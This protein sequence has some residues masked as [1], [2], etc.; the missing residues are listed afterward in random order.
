MLHEL[1]IRNFAIIDDLHLTFGPGL[2]ILTGE[3]G[4]GKSIIIDALGLLQGDRGAAEWVRAGTELAQIEAIF[5]LPSGSEV[6]TEVSRILAEQELDDPDSPDWITLNREVRRNGRNVCRVN[7]RN[8]S[9]QILSD[10]AALLID[11]HGQGEHLNLLRPRTHIRLLD[12]FASLMPLRNQLAQQVA[13]LRKIRAELQRL[14]QD[15]RT[16][17]QRVDLLSFQAEEIAQARLRPG[18]EETLAS[19]RLRLGNAEALLQLAQAAATILNVGESEMPGAI[20]LVSEA[21]GRIERLARIDRSMQSSADDAQG[22]LE[23]LSDLAR[24]LQDYADQLEFNPERLQEVEERLELIA[25]LKRK[26]GDTLEQIIA[27]GERAQTELDSLSN[28]EVKTAELEEQEDK[29][30]HIIG[31]L[32]W[33]LSAERRQAGETLARRVE[34]ELADLRMER[35]RFGVA[36]EQSERADGAYLPDGRRVAFDNTGIDQVEFLISANPGE[37]LKPMAKVASG[38]ETARLMLALKSVLTHADATPTLI[39]DEIDQGIGGRVGAVVGQKLWFLTGQQHGVNGSGPSR[40][41]TAKKSAKERITEKATAEVTEK[42]HDTDE[43]FVPHQVLCITHL[44]QLA[45][46]GDKHFTVNKRVFQVEGEERTST[47]VRDLDAAERIE[48]LTVMLGATSEAG[49]RSVEEM[50]A[51]VARVKSSG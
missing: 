39:F 29:L 20:D 15:A 25:N 43:E 10:V 34:T 40:K 35:A 38:G 5:Q 27:F 46:Y 26:Y 32:A 19:E 24:S 23:Q 47:V 17:A 6:E 4:A 44:P 41:E 13:M 28:W 11:V 14:R 50:M 12:R 9:L 45:A 2:N 22:L 51:D 21:A 3:T 33:Q 48:E 30:L 8:V 18:E 31:K 37:P 16:I 42:G 36:I 7:G 49:R 1:S